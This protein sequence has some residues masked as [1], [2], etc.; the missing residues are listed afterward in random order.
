[1]VA[2]P[3]AYV[4]PAPRAY[5]PVLQPGDA[6]PDAPLVDQAGRPFSFQR[7]GGRTTIVSFVYTRCRDARMCPLVAAKFA[8]LQGTVRGTPIRLVIITLDPAYD[9]PRV[10][11]RYGAAYGED[12][13]VWTFVTGKP[14]DVQSLAERFGILI[15]RP[16]PGLVSHTEAAIVLDRE[17]RVATVVDGA[18]WL[19]VDL[20]AAAHEAAGENGNPLRRLS[21]WLRSSASAL[22]GS[23]RDAGITVAAASVLFAA[24]LIGFWAIA[25]R[26]VEGRRDTP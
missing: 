9:T 19:P 17:A 2:T 8:R 16:L 25:R 13:T 10:L 26:M 4:S 6:V 7:T 1:M 23:G 3:A 20:L 24:L 18:A 22:C 11:A 15:D 12:P 21:L 5:V 14:E